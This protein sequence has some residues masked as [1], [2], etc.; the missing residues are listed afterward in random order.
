MS[1]ETIR[2]SEGQKIELTSYPPYNPDLAPND[3]YLFPS[4]KNELRGQRF[5]FPT[6]KWKKC[7]KRSEYEEQPY[8][9]VGRVPGIDD[10]R[11]LGR[12]RRLAPHVRRLSRPA[13]IA[14]RWPGLRTRHRRKSNSRN[15]TRDTRVE[16]GPR[17]AQR[18]PGRASP[19]PPTSEFFS[20]P[21][22]SGASRRVIIRKRL[23]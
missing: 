15:S 19:S 2:F 10:I 5:S 6:V 16:S 1:A 18:R 11:G 12:Y 20:C 4:V 22:P 7:Y 17:L 13:A 14:S 9:V 8:T 3:F 23:E 21:S